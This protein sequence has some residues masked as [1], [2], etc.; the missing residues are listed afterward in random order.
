[1]RW[2]KSQPN[3][4]LYNHSY[5]ILINGGSWSDKINVLSNLIKLQ[6]L[7]IDKIYL[8]IKDPFESHVNTY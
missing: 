7:D 2:N 8:Y 4:A 6:W 3:L 1:M 5:R